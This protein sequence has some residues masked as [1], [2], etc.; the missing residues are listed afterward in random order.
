MAQFLDTLA[1]R[2]LLFDGAIGSWLYDHGVLHTACYDEL[3]L[4]RP[5]LLREI[6]RAYRDAG[7]DILETNT[8]GANRIALERHGQADRT[9]EINRA[10]VQLAR[11]CADGA[12]VAGAVGPTGVRFTVATAAERDQARAAFAEQITALTDAGVDLLVFETFTSIVELETALDAARSVAPDV[13]RVAQMVFDADGTAEGGLT[14]DEVARR[15]VA[16]GAD[17]VGANCGH[18]PP[19]LYPVGAQMVTAGVPVSI[20]PNAG[21]PAHV[22]GRTLYVANPEHFGVF[23]R[24]MLKSGVRL[25]GGCCGTTPE[26]VRAM[27]GAVR[28]MRG[29]RADANLPADVVRSG[30]PPALVPLA[31]R[32][33]LGA[34][35]AEGRFAVSMELSAPSGTDTTAALD[36]V[37]RAMAGGVEIVNVADGPRAQSRMSN[38]AFCAQAIAHT[39]VEPIVHVCCRDRNYL[40]LIAHLLGAH[41]LGVRDLVIITGDPPKMGDYAFA[42]PVYDVDSIGLLEIAAGLNAGVD[43]TGATLAGGTSFVLATGA[44]PAA[45][46]RDRELERLARKKAAGA[47][48]VMTQPVYDPATLDSFLDDAADI[49]LPVMVGLLPLASARNAE[50]LHHEVPGM[51]IPQHFRDRMSAAGNGPE[52]RDEGIAIAREALAAVQDRVAGAYIMPPFNRVDAAL[53]ILDEVRGTRWL[54]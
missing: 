22:D 5:A 10:G 18:G 9:V 42:T 52:A 29:E 30:P 8:F 20:Q 38:V 13:P 33:K 14:P 37:R 6:H 51:Q 16:A 54:P 1:E 23:A 50:F 45:V 3:N 2:P 48:L 53:A 17:V 35:I 26:H 44:E 47:E 21:H 12:F 19:E 41:A 11:E 25:I 40:G 43:P 28:M 34:A 24:R 31:E 27:Q 46:D 15:L 4:S 49:G 7:A 39:G 32:S 36:R